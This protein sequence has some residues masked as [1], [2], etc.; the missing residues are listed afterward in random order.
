MVEFNKQ[1]VLATTGTV[2][3]T[4]VSSAS[5]SSKVAL[6]RFNNPAGFT[7]TLQ[8]Y[9]ASTASTITLYTLT[10]SAGDIVTDAFN[11]SL[12]EGDQLI[13][14]SNVTGTTYYVYG[15][16]YATNG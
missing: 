2:L 8:R 15:I 11:Y 13:A 6:L 16:D 7:L 4:G 3:H 12:E 10:L 9:E 14:T 5:F 1:G